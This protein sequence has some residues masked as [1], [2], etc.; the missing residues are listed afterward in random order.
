[1]RR[2]EGGYH[3]ML[4]SVV[5]GADPAA[6][7]AGC[8]LLLTAIM[9]SGL[10]PPARAAVA[11]AML[12]EAPALAAA[13]AAEAQ[14]REHAAAAAAGGAGA[15]GAGAGAGAE[16]GADGGAAGGGFGPGGELAAAMQAQ[17]APPVDRHLRLGDAAG[18]AVAGAAGGEEGAAAEEELEYD[19]DEEDEDAAQ[20]Q[21][22]AGGPVVLRWP[23]PLQVRLT[24]SIT[25]CDAS[26]TRLQ[27]LVQH[28]VFFAFGCAAAPQ[29]TRAVPSVHPPAAAT[30]GRGLGGCAQGLHVRHHP[31][32]HAAARHACVARPALCAHLRARRHPAV[33]GV[34]NVRCWSPVLWRCLY[35]LTWRCCLLCTNEACSLPC[36]RQFVGHLLKRPLLGA[37]TIDVFPSAP[38]ACR[39]LLLLLLTAR[40]DPKSNTPLRSY[41]LLPNDDLSR[42]IDDWVS[43]D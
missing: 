32:A 20:G 30:R 13:L 23:A 2:H 12:E 8:R 24:H 22:R 31:G 27:G 16:T 1:M 34:S 21:G 9:D 4:L 19:S 5:E 25:P 3:L 10:G 40:R 38:A 28:V 6:L 29:P 11:A 26:W 15:A 14:R 41:S 37:R 33:A 17:V 42:A 39:L 35:R 7:P 36:C 18:G 43:V